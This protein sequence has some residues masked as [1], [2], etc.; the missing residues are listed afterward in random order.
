MSDDPD[1][2]DLKAQTSQGDRLDSAAKEVD[3]Q[4]LVDDIVDELETI[5]A[6]DQQKT[7]SVWDGQLAAFI[8]ALEGNP[9]HLDAVG[10]GL[11]EQLDIEETETDRSSV[12]RLALR[13]GFQ[14]AAPEQFEAVREAV[15]KQAT[16]GL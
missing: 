14:E 5:D 11:Q 6:G 16:K 12:L 10:N 8:R 2:E 1:L 13:V 3:R 7:V 4:D 9:E 15:R